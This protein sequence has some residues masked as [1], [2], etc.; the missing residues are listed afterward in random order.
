MGGGEPGG[1]DASYHPPDGWD[2]LG[3]AATDGE[4]AAAAMEWI[5]GNVSFLHD[6]AGRRRVAGEPWSAADAV[7]LIA[8]R[9]STGGGVV[10]SLRRHTKGELIIDPRAL[11]LRYLNGAVGEMRRERRLHAERTCDLPTG[12]SAGDATASPMPRAPDPDAEADT[13]YAQ[14]IDILAAD[15]DRVG[16]SPRPAAPEQTRRMLAYLDGREAALYQILRRYAPA[17]VCRL[18]DAWDPDSRRCVLLGVFPLDLPAAAVAGYR[19]LRAEDG[20]AAEMMTP[21]RTRSKIR[22]L[23]KEIEDAWPA[24]QVPHRRAESQPQPAEAPPSRR[25]DGEEGSR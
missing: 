25:A 5:A 18:V 17:E 8:Y 7:S 1:G 13:S 24:G 4:L 12:A 6:E 21:G 9:A 11:L 22:G 10:H 15:L 20:T 16:R 3:P 14:V 19:R 2:D 23:R